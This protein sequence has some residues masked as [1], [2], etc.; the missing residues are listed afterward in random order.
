[1]NFS[2]LILKVIA[3]GVILLANLPI[4]SNDS[5]AVFMDP[6]LGHGIRILTP[7]V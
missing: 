5:I 2:L 7:R 6:L 1:M 4:G 3:V